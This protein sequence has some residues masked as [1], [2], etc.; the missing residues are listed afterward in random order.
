MQ[1][2]EE[3]AA[4]YLEALRKLQGL[5]LPEAARAGKN[6]SVTTGH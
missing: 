5:S 2:V 1:E 3:V 4:A 6:K